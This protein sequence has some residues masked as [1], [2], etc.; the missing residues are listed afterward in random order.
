MSISRGKG[1]TDSCSQP[2]KLRQEA[3]ESG[4]ENGFSLENTCNFEHPQ[5]GRAARWITESHHASCLGE[6]HERVEQAILIAPQ[7]CRNISMQ[8]TGQACQGQNGPWGWLA[9][10]SWVCAGGVCLLLLGLCFKLDAVLT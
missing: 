6:L 7:Q 8:G 5:L 9:V 3:Q 1:M 4:S 10:R 2:G